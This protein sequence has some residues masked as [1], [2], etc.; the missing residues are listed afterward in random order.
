MKTHHLVLLASL[1]VVASAG[2]H[3]TDAAIDLRGE[4]VQVY[5]CAPDGAGFAWRFTAPEATLFDA[6]GQK[7]GRHFAGPSWQAADGSLVVGTTRVSSAAPDASA[8][9]WLV[10]RV[11]SQSGAGRFAT[12]RTITRTKTEGGAM[13]ATGCD[14]AHAGAEARVPYS[15]EYTFFPAAP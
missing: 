5:T 10:L 3:A 14:P 4:G 2:A 9:P 13:P 1:G 8:I 11:K 6:A 7:V 15:A 12:V